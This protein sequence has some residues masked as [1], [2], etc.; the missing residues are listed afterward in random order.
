[1]LLQLLQARCDNLIKRFH[2]QQLRYLN[3]PLRPQRENLKDL[4]LGEFLSISEAIQVV[5]LTSNLHH[6]LGRI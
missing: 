1:L 6:E 2:P 3:Y 4:V 5:R